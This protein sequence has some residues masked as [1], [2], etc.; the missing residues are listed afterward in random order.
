MFVADP[1]IDRLEPGDAQR[2]CSAIGRR[3]VGGVWGTSFDGGGCCE[4]VGYKHVRSVLACC[5]AMGPLIWALSLL[6]R[7]KR[8]RE[9]KSIT[10]PALEQ[11]GHPT[12]EPSPHLSSFFISDRPGP[13]IKLP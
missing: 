3:W 7:D 13:I 11:Q 6:C 10:S 4:G 5:H 9:R 2:S 8:K 12:R 1:T